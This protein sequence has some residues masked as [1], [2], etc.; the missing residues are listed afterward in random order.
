MPVT[1]NKRSDGSRTSTDKESKVIQKF[2]SCDE[3]EIMPI[4]T[5]Y[6]SVEQIKDYIQNWLAN[7]D[8]SIQ[9]GKSHRIAKRWIY[10]GTPSQKR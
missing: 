10:A 3:F 9:V 2:D 4:E 5:D 6:T 1:T 7:E 8:S